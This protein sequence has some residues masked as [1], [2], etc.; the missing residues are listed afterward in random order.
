MVNLLLGLGPA[1]GRLREEVIVVLLHVCEQVRTPRLHSTLPTPT[2]CPQ[3]T[4]PGLARCARAHTPRHTQDPPAWGTFVEKGGV[5]G[6]LL[7]AA[8]PNSTAQRRAALELRDMAS[9]PH[10]RFVPKLLPPFRARL[11]LRYWSH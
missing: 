7:L 10:L 9:R 2:G 11:S 4:Q 1:D 8:S 3:C 5:R 6:L